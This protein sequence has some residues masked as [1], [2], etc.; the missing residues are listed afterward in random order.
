MREKVEE[1]LGRIRPMLQ[2][3]GGDVQLVDV[4]DNGVVKVRLKG[5]CGGCPMAGIKSITFLVTGKSAYGYM[6]AE[7]GVHRLVRIS[8]FDSSGRR[9]TS[10]A[11]VDVIPEV[12]ENTEVEINPDDLQMDTYRA[13]GPGGQY[14]NKTDSAVRITHLPT[15]LVVQC[16]SERSQLSNRL[17]AMN[18]LRSQLLDMKRREQEEKLA[19][20]RGEQREIAWGNQIRSYVFEP[21]TLVKDHRTSVEVGN[22]QAVMDGKIDIFIEAYLRL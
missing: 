6:K 21:Y 4:D 5:A 13:S 11:S 18:M 8:P 15:G 7:R 22:I 16:Q 20:L 2:A 3:D 12:K 19:K 14:V 9:H 10:F 1:A 17:R